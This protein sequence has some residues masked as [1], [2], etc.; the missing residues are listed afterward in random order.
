MR[1]LP[2]MPS[3]KLASCFSSLRLGFEHRC[4]EVYYQRGQE[5]CGGFPWW[6]S[7]PI[8]HRICQSNVGY[9]ITQCRRNTSVSLLQHNT[10]VFLPGSAIRQHV[11]CKSDMRWGLSTRCGQTTLHCF[12][13]TFLLCFSFLSLAFQLIAWQSK[14]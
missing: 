6:G 4:H 8:C 12:Q 2:S 13:H 11:Y 14:T 3:Y 10:V 9:N 7:T 1:E 5:G